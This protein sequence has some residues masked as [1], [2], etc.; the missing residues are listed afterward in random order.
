MKLLVF[1]QPSRGPTSVMLT[2]TAFILFLSTAGART[3]PRCRL[4]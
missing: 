1:Q 3:P 4:V 2:S